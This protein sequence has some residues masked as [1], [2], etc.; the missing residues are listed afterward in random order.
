MGVSI[1]SNI[2]QI[3]N[4][5]MCNNMG[6]EEVCT[7]ETTSG[8]Y[9]TLRSLSVATLVL[10]PLI[11][12]IATYFLARRRSKL[13]LTSIVEICHT[14][15]S[16]TNYGAIL[17]KY[18]SAVSDNNS[19]KQFGPALAM[20]CN[21]IVR[22]EVR[23]E[24]DRLCSI[25]STD[26]SG[27]QR[28]SGV[29]ECFAFINAATKFPEGLRE[30]KAKMITVLVALIHHCND[31]LDTV[32]PYSPIRQEDVDVI[33]N[34]NALII[35]PVSNV[36]TRICKYSKFYRKGLL[37]RKNR[38]LDVSITI[39][40]YFQFMNYEGDRRLKDSCGQALRSVQALINALNGSRVDYSSRDLIVMLQVHIVTDKSSLK[41]FGEMLSSQFLLKNDHI[42]TIVADEKS[43]ARQG[44]SKAAGESLSARGTGVEERRSSRSRSGTVSE[45]IRRTS[46]LLMNKLTFPP[47][48]SS[49]HQSSISDKSRV[50]SPGLDESIKNF[51]TFGASMRVRSAS[52][53]NAKLSVAN[54]RMSVGAIGGISESREISIQD[55][56]KMLD[57]N[58][59]CHILLPPLR[60]ETA[61][62]EEG[63]QYLTIH[64]LEML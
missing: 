54:S 35:L 52:K 49:S 19:A 10:A 21:V 12:T 7:V 64:F 9:G 41:M 45:A 28:I 2:A 38:I 25:V 42:S 3:I 36:L 26:I 5:V 44:A 20:C 29:K 15:R 33:L 1:A 43:V 30:V 24:L 37:S 27:I 46:V 40:N 57:R 51:S 31:Y 17:E 59:R 63:N 56:E 11:T 60:G 53:G 32:R 23:S 4:G 50:S 6:L 39:Y 48:I 13:I 62:E 34:I 8:S 16:E 55:L 47:M 58:K 22:E 14:V 18:E 61:N